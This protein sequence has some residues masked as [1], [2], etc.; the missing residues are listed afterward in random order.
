MV[1]NSSPGRPYLGRR[2]QMKKENEHRINN[3]STAQE[4]RV[5]GE[6]IE[7][8]VYRNAK[9]LKCAEEREGEIDEI[10]KAADATGCKVIE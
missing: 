9:A 2:G 8:G 3:E 7:T 10:S 5:E 6:K 1:Q 4:V